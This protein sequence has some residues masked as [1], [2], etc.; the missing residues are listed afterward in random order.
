ML[1]EF[2]PTIACTRL[3]QPHRLVECN[4]RNGA[5]RHDGFAREAGQ[6]R[7]P[8]SAETGPIERVSLRVQVDQAQN[9]AMHAQHQMVVR[10][11]VFNLWDSTQ[12]DIVVWHPR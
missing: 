12:R 6:V 8:R 9:R 7:R 4:G 1:L 3:A 5:D 2:G 10:G 11:I